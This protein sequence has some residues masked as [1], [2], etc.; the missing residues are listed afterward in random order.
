MRLTTSRV[1][2]I[3]FVVLILPGIIVAGLIAGPVLAIAWVLED[4]RA[5]L[6]TL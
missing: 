1:L 4:V 5:T 3:A 6:R 2:L